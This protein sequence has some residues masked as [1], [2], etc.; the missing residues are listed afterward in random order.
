MYVSIGIGYNELLIPVE[1][2]GS[3]LKDVEKAKACKSTGYGSSK[4]YNVID[5]PVEI[6]FV[7][8]SRVVIPGG[9]VHSCLKDLSEMTTR[10]WKAEEALKKL[11][12]EF[13]VFKLKFAPF[14]EKEVKDESEIGEGK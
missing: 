12:D 6:A 4:L 13:N 11:K 1:N 3:L 7:A 14:L 10:A 2:I 9:E 8:D 5:E